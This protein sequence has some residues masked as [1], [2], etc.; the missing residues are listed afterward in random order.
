MNSEKGTSSPSASSAQGKLNLRAE[1]R[2]SEVMSG[3]RS[4]GMNDSFV[5]RK[6]GTELINT[7]ATFFLQL[8]T[9]SLPALRSHLVQ[10]GIHAQVFDPID[11]YENRR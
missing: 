3:L 2:V 4:A 9:S 10:R 5:L 1:A 11:T 7:H 6:L 8:C